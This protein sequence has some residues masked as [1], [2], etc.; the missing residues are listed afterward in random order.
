VHAAGVDQDAA[1]ARDEQRQE[2]AGAVIHAPPVNGERALPHLP[3]AAD[4]AFA[5]T[6]TRVAEDQVDVIAGV[7]VEQLIAEP[8][9]LR[10]IGDVTG[11]AGDPDAGR[12]GPPRPG[13]GPR[14]GVRVQ[15]AC[16]DRASLRR[17]LA[18]KLAAHA[19]TA[20]GH[21]RKLPRERVH[22]PTP[23]TGHAWPA[24]TRPGSP[25]AGTGPGSLKLISL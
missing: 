9:D 17:Q 16:R 25:R 1:A 7:P 18:D 19:G 4:E 12:G 13:R 22:S 6:D 20:S 2:R 24:N 14:D 3:A 10:L 15:V 8:Q 11:M 5:A 21:H 23:P